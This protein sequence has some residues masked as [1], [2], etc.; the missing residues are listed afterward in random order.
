MGAVVARCFSELSGRR[1]RALDG[2]STPRTRI[3]AKRPLSTRAWKLHAHC[4]DAAG[5]VFRTKRQTCQSETT[6]IRNLSD[7]PRRRADAQAAQLAPGSRLIT[8]RLVRTSRVEEQQ[9]WIAHAR[10]N[11]PL[12]L[13]FRC[14]ER[15]CVQEL[16]SPARPAPLTHCVPPR[17]GTRRVKRGTARAADAPTSRDHGS[18]KRRWSE[19]S[20][21]FPSRTTPSASPA[22]NLE[23][24]PSLRSALLEKQTETQSDLLLGR[25]MHQLVLLETRVKF[26][27]PR[28]EK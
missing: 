16:S 27:R 18:A 5:A 13:L 3:W 24:S 1:T 28:D 7:R 9:M 23:S 10:T 21:L 20:R 4:G 8:S 19:R 6:R 15:S 26:R 25:G 17:G 12:R 11:P 14:I 2:R 22:A